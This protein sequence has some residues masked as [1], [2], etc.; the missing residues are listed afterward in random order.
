MTFFKIILIDKQQETLFYQIIFDRSQNDIQ[1][2]AELFG[3]IES[4][5]QTLKLETYSLSQTS[6]EQ[7]FLSFVKEQKSEEQRGINEAIEEEKKTKR[8][9]SLIRKNKTS[10]EEKKDLPKSTAIQMEQES[11]RF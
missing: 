6:L 2:I 9:E 3:L 4:N 7:V 5:K 10:P 8:K 1:S 11:T